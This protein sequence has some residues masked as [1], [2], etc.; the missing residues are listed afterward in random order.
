MLIMRIYALYERSRK[1][2]A[3]YIVFAVIFFI[4]GLV[5]HDFSEYKYP[6]FKFVVKWAILDGKKEEPHAQILVRVGCG[7]IVGRE[8]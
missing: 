8:R 5:S 3:L 6:S 1:V 7:V 2:I 4:V